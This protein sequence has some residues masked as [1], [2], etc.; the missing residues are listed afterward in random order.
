MSGK[1]QQAPAEEIPYFDNLFDFYRHIKTR[2]PLHDGF[3]IREINPDALR[4]Y[5]YLAK[6]F[7]HS[8]YCIALFMEGD[9]NLNAGFWKTHI[10][11]PAL[12]FKT[13][14]GSAFSSGMIFL[15]MGRKLSVKICS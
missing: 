6:P 11:K 1:K 15:G 4:Q 10:N 3:D 8:F 7:R 9:V 12:Y 13:A 5:D 14:I 2:P